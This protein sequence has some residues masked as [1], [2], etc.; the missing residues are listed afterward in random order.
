MTPAGTSIDVQNEW[1]EN[2]HTHTHNA[3]ISEKAV[4]AAVVQF[5]IL[6]MK[7]SLRDHSV[8]ASSIYKIL[9]MID[10]YLLR[11]ASEARV[12]RRRRRYYLI[13]L[14]LPNIFTLACL[15]LSSI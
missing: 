8:G 1:E 10:V 15:P 3:N 11:K 14:L 7:K 13:V 2:T 9:G 12:N 4:Q 6:I 5:R